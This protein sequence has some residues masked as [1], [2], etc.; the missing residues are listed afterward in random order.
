[1]I[2]QKQLTYGTEGIECNLGLIDTHFF[3]NK[4]SGVQRYAL[5]NCFDIVKDFKKDWTKICEIR[6]NGNYKYKNDRTIDTFLLVKTLFKN[7]DKYLANIEWTDAMINTQ[8][9]DKVETFGSLEYEELTSNQ[10][11]QVKKK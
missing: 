2:I 5:E 6:S 3:I 10:I 11:N 7:R 8:Y 1:L 9:V 4:D